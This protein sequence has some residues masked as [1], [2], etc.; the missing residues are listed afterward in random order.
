MVCKLVA[1]DLERSAQIPGLENLSMFM[2]WQISSR[3]AWIEHFGQAPMTST[4]ETVQQLEQ[5]VRGGQ[6]RAQ[7]C[8]PPLGAEADLRPCVRLPVHVNRGPKQPRFETTP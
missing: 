5:A 1:Q 6:S 7:P 4:D 8:W 2:E 3:Q